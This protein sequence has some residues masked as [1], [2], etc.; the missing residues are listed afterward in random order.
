MLEK[1]NFLLIQL[2]LWWLC[3]RW[4][5]SWRHS[6]TIQS[7]SQNTYTT[8]QI[9]WFM[10][11]VWRRAADG[12]GVISTHQWQF[13]LK[14]NWRRNK[15]IEST[16]FSYAVHIQ[17]VRNDIPTPANCKASLINVWLRYMSWFTDDECLSPN[18]NT[19]SVETPIIFALVILACQMQCE[20]G[21]IQCTINAIWFDL[22]LLAGLRQQNRVPCNIT[23]RMFLLMWRNLLIYS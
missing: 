17:S 22:I 11:H 14:R 9:R 21:W 8:T 20:W 2:I 3:F 15:S 12:S 7:H 16:C 23:I 18:A 13:K 10:G 6:T 5:L 4:I 1:L 19:T